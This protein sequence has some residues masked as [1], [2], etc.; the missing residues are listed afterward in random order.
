[1]YEQER[2][3]G[4]GGININPYY[5]QLEIGRIR[6]V[7]VH[8]GHRRTGIGR[9]LVTRI[10]SGASVHFDSLQLYTS[11][12]RAARFYESLGYLAVN[13]KWKVS[14]IKLARYQPTE[15]TGD[16]DRDYHSGR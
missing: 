7:Y 4:M 11:Q 12:L 15:A 3:I 13:G 5:N 6:H 9:A 8:L 2:L 16:Q 10:E 14:H 1:M